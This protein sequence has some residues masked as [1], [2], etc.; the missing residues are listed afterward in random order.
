M[1]EEL[2]DMPYYLYQP[3]SMRMTPMRNTIR[4]MPKRTIS[5]RVMTD[6]VRLLSLEL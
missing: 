2:G 3:R 5:I 4:A 1:L 6:K